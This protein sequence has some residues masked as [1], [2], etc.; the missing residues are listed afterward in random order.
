MKGRQSKAALRVAI[1]PWKSL[2]LH[3]QV[4]GRDVAVRKPGHHIER[5]RSEIEIEMV[6]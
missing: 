3:H 5:K 2:A 4:H 1:L 6:T